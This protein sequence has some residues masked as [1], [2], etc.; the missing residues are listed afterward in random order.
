M[1]G[2]KSRIGRRAHRLLRQTHRQ[3][4]VIVCTDRGLRHLLDDAVT[5][6]IINATKDVCAVKAGLAAWKNFRQSR[7]SLL[8]ALRTG[9]SFV[10]PDDLAG[11]PA[12]VKL[13]R[14]RPY[15]FAANKAF[16]QRRIE[17]EITCDGFKRRIGS[18][19]APADRVLRTWRVSQQ[20]VLGRTLPLTERTLGQKLQ[21]LYAHVMWRNIK[22][23]WARG[24]QNPV[25]LPR[26]RNDQISPADFDAPLIEYDCLWAGVIPNRFLP[27]SGLL[28]KG[29]TLLT[30][31]LP[32]F[33]ILGWV[34]VVN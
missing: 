8:P 4:N 30:S 13:T 5:W 26:I 25:V 17:R 32:H 19:I 15:S 28:S 2:A 23:R 1:T 24:L 29:R 14:L 31:V 6:I 16:H 3:E 10:W 22:C 18:R 21:E 34:Y 9:L 27:W 11:N 33:I 12:A 20:P 7:R